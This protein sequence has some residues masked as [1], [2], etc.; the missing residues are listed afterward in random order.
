MSFTKSSQLKVSTNC[1]MTSS[2]VGGLNAEEYSGVLRLT[3]IEDHSLEKSRSHIRPR[4]KLVML[5]VYCTT[6]LACLKAGQ[7]EG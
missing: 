4:I 2:T 5:G 1:P 7:I 3:N 6:E